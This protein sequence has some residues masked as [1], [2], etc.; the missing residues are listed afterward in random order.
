M[1]LLLFRFPLLA[2]LAKSKGCLDF[3]RHDKD[4]K[5]DEDVCTVR[6]DQFGLQSFG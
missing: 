2:L 5:D 4:D 1:N 6:P 3:A